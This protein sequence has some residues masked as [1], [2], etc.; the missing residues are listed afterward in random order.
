MHSSALAQKRLMR[1]QMNEMAAQSF[2]GVKKAAREEATEQQFDRKLA[3]PPCEEV[4][5]KNSKTGK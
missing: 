5:S 2:F 3:A 4:D 1:E